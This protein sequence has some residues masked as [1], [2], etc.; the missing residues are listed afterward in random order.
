LQ[1]RAATGRDIFGREV[2][3]R[4][5]KT[6]VKGKKVR[7]P[8]RPESQRRERERAERDR[9]ARTLIEELRA[10]RK[11]PVREDVL[12]DEHGQPRL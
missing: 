9:V 2:T 10:L 3:E 8:A 7:P 12:Y 4:P 11:E 1:N 5:G 6:M